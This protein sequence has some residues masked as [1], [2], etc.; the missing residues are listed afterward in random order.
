MMGIRE[1]LD[2]LDLLVVAAECLR[3]G[4]EAEVDD[5]RREVDVLEQLG[6]P[7]L[8]EDRELHHVGDAVRL[9]QAGQQPD[10]KGS[11]QPKATRT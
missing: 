8:A 2:P 10:Q 6:G 3:E 4:E 5:S 11:S 1:L 9:E 7:E